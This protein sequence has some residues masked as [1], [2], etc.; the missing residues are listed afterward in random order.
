MSVSQVDFKGLLIVLLI[1][2]SIGA[3]IDYFSEKVHWVTGGLIA[4][5]A[6]WGNGLII[7]VEDRDPSGWD[8]DEN[9]SAKSKNEFKTAYRIQLVLTGVV[10]ILGICSHV[11]FQRMTIP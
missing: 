6:F 10:L 3:G 5:F 8:C 1:C 11:Y 4:L 2:F 7:S 9:E